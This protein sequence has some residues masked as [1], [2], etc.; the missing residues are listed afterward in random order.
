MSESLEE[1]TVLA[2]PNDIKKQDYSMTNTYD[3]DMNEDMGHATDFLFS[4]SVLNQ[5]TLME[6]K[7]ALFE[8]FEF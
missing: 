6:E 1:T 7:D 4:H 5:D 3:L 8:D 2:H